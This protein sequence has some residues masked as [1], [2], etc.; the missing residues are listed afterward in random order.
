MTALCSCNLNLSII[1]WKQ[2]RC[3]CIFCS[4][5]RIYFQVKCYCIWIRKCLKRSC[6]CCTVKRQISVFTDLCSISKCS[7]IAVTACIINCLSIRRYILEII[8]QYQGGVW[9]RLHC[10]VCPRSFCKFC[11]SH[12]ILL[13]CIWIIRSSP[14]LF[15]YN[16]CCSED[17][18]VNILFCHTFLALISPDSSLCSKKIWLT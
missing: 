6:Q 12:L 2:G 9:I 5:F 10:N 14:G 16:R 7:V 15:A 17:S 3:G 18:L 1:T 8:I 13:K 4:F 11:S